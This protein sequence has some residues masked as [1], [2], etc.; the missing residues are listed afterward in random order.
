M[1]NINIEV[2]YFE[3]CPHAD[4]MLKR[5]KKAVDLVEFQVDY[6][7]ILVETP[8]EA[9]QIK[10]RGSPTLLVNK[11]DFEK[12]PEPEFANLSC[13]FY[14][15]GLPTVESIEKFISQFQMNKGKK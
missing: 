11:I 3:G 13:R 7:E 9:R 15:N 4:E 6:Q 2:Q 1:L 12:L 10:F 8:V 5:V 14:K